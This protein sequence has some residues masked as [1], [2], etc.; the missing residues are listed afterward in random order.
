MQTIRI[1]LGDKMASHA[2]YSVLPLTRNCS[3]K[4]CP[5]D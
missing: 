5:L 3:L 4:S 2:L 1:D